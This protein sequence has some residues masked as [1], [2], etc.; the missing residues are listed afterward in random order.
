MASHH[1]QA[2]FSI[3]A[4][5]L[6]VPG[7]GATFNDG[8]R[9][10][11]SVVRATR[12]MAVG[13]TS[14]Y[15]LP[16]YSP[17]YVSHHP[18]VIQHFP[19]RARFLLPAPFHSALVMASNVL[20]PVFLCPQK[21]PWPTHLLSTGRALCHWWRRIAG[22][23]KLTIRRACVLL[24]CFVLYAVACAQTLASVVRCGQLGA[25]NSQPPRCLC[26]FNM[27]AECRRTEQ[28]VPCTQHIICYIQELQSRLS[29]NGSLVA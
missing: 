25:T 24:S 22:S 5:Y 19:P 15:T 16:M 6:I 3:Q 20:L 18:S 10:P 27:R 28:Q 26:D 9:P 11:S 1:L 13:A 23:D 7:R 29:S 4:Y 17:I 12:N 21:D 2:G 8:D 14:C